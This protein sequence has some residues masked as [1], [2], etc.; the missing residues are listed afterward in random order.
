MLTSLP[1]FP[2]NAALVQGLVLPLHI[3][4]PRYCR[5]V[6]ELLANPDAAGREF[7]MIAVR[8]GHRVETGGIS[9]LYDIG[10]TAILR[11][12][13]A[14]DDGRYDIVT[15]GRRRF[16][17]DSIVLPPGDPTASF[18]EA[19]VEFLDDEGTPTD[20]NEQHREEVEA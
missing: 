18:I 2:L 16:R 10:T 9:A 17:L 7:G 19:E 15:T 14:Y 5:L 8:D 1:L 3:F 6:E 13:T 20:P 4:E 12:S 11:E